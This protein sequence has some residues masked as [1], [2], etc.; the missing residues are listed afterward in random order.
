MFTA[1]FEKT[2]IIIK[3]LLQIDFNRDVKKA[4]KAL[5]FYASLYFDW[6]NIKPNIENFYL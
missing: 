5:T 3:R 4:L 2:L 1:F 6:D